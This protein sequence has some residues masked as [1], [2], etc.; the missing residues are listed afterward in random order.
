MKHNGHFYEGIV[1]VKISA[2]V[3]KLEGI[4]QS[5]SAKENVGNNTLPAISGSS[6]AFDVF[7]KISEITTTL[8]EEKF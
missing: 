2:F 8:N 5:L 7:T 1:L 4:S 6:Y 3:K